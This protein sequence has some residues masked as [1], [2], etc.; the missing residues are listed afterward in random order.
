MK[1]GLV[2]F[3]FV[4]VA[5]ATS[6]ANWTYTSKDL[7][8]TKIKWLVDDAEFGRLAPWDA[9][10]APPP[11]SLSKIG[12]SARKYLD[13]RYGAKDWRLRELNLVSTTKGKWI[14]HMTFGTTPPGTESKERFTAIVLHDGTVIEPKATQH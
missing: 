3:I 14:Y 13:A 7:D 5:A 11:V 10:R 6:F 2:V 8:G 9:F 12:N 4:V 1:R